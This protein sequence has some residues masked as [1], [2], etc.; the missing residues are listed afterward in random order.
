MV[1]KEAK[2]S[3]LELLALIHAGSVHVIEVGMLE[4]CQ[5]RDA[6]VRI[7]SDQTGKQVDLELVKCGCVITHRHA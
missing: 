5:G 2:K 1:K 3:S 4:G 7:Q 6:S